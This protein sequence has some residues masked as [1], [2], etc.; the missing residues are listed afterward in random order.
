[1][2][3]Q[4]FDVPK[5][6]QATLSPATSPALGAPWHMQGWGYASAEPSQAPGWDAEDPLLVAVS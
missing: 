1:M 5:V 3:V 4:A 6:A 2:P